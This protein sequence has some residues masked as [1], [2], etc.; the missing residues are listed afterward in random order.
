MWS[1]SGDRKHDN[2]CKVES[3]RTKQAAIVLTVL[4]AFCPR[5]FGLNPA[6]DIN[7]YA[8]TAW[9][10][11][12]GFF[13]GSIYA[14]A[15]TPDGYLW[16]GT[17]F[18]LARFDG[19]RSLEWQPP[20]GE[21]LPGGR[22]RSLLAARDGRL[23]IGTDEGLASWKEGKLTHC[24]ELAG[25]TVLSMLE[26]HDA[27]IWAAGWGVRSTDGRLCTIR[28]GRVQCDGNDGS[29]SNGMDGLYE[30]GAGKLWA[31]SVD[32]VWRWKPGPAKFFPMPIVTSSF[33]EGGGGELFITIL[34]GIRRLI[35]E[36]PG[37]YL[38]RANG[39]NSKFGKLLRDREGGLWVGTY[40]GGLLHIYRGKTHRFTHSDGLSGDNIRCLF[41]DHEG[42][43]SGTIPENMSPAALPGV[44]A[45]APTSHAH[46]LSTYA[47]D[48]SRIHPSS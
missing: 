6:L 24:P 25:K 5:A 45:E 32:G 37:P 9:T 3:A 35:D 17:E 10:V 43:I 8:H 20:K 22:I 7:Q 38:L 27:T 14:I 33:A 31:G 42:G 41:E 2:G 40:D 46:R 36:Q 18:G 19:V 4:A 39:R 13:T 47:A 30:D 21:R 1:D 11:R 15:Q 29:L 28:G 44:Y 34:D 12:E 26:D 23:W 16:I 48:P